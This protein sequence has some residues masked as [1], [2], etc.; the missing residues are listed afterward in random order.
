MVS[1]DKLAEPTSDINKCEESK[2]DLHNF[3]VFSKSTEENAVHY[4]SFAAKY[5]GMQEISGFNDPYEIAK[6]TLEK[7]G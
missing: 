5:D 3:G 7:L 2:D 6:V 4:N 1:A